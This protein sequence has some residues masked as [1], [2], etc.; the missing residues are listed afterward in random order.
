LSEKKRTVTFLKLTEEVNELEEI[1]SDIVASINA[2]R[3]GTRQ[4][5]I[6]DLISKETL[7]DQRPTVKMLAK[8]WYRLG[9]R[10]DLINNSK[11]EVIENDE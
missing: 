8:E 5:T 9:L 1:R 4:D 7:K 6:E 10:K 3:H 11:V 2:L